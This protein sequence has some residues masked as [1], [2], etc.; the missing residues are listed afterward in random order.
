MTMDVAIENVRR[1]GQYPFAST[2]ANNDSVQDD[3]SQPAYSA[4]FDPDDGIKRH[5]ACDECSTMLGV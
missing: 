5:A 3:V 4:A 2:F 1:F